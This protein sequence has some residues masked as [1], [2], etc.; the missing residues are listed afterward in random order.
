MESKRIAYDEGMR[1]NFIKMGFVPAGKTDSGYDVFGSNRIKDILSE[2]QFE[3]FELQF[4]NDVEISEILG[5]SEAT[6][7]AVR[8]RIKE[9]G[10]FFDVDKVI[11]WGELSRLLS[12]TRSVV[13]RNRMPKK[14]EETVENLRKSILKWGLSLKN[15]K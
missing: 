5:I 7:E 14:H 15:K 8:K 10:C 3:V 2:R 12:G 1:K 4:K 9:K 11:N 6:V 13:T